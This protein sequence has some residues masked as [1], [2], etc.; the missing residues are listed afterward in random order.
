M[1][2]KSKVAF[3]SIVLLL[4]F[5]LMGY[6]TNP[7]DVLNYFKTMKASDVKY[8]EFVSNGAQNSFNTK[9]ASN[10]VNTFVKLLNRSKSAVETNFPS[11][12]GGYAGLVL[13][14][15]S[16]ENFSFYNV[17]RGFEIDYGNKK[18]KIS[19]P[20][21]DIFFN[22]MYK[23]YTAEYS[24]KK[25]SAQI[26]YNSSSITKIIFYDSRAGKVSPVT[27]EDKSKIDEFMVDVNKYLLSKRNVTRL[28]K[29]FTHNI[30]FYSNDKLIMK[31]SFTNPFFITIN[32]NYYIADNMILNDTM[33][34]NFL[35]SI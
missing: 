34:E 29:G 22:L 3:I 20:Q 13:C 8:C 25:I 7:K 15:K 11:Y 9:L 12:K 18:Y 24:Q 27:V 30:K 26:N 14:M 31:L 5:I 33:I 6:T 32:G 21:Y 4:T 35:N 23:K 1:L 16:K 2:N 28:P 10:D 17:N 19:Q